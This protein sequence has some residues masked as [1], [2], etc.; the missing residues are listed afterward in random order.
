MNNPYA[1]INDIDLEYYGVTCHE[2]DIEYCKE[3]L[4]KL[5]EPQR[6]IVSNMY[7]LHF[8]KILSKGE[9][10]SEG[11]ARKHCN[12]LLMNFKDKYNE[13]TSGKMYMPPKM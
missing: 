3:Q 11:Q 10:K 5:T 4:Q 7:T 9:I 13:L 1:K 6:H 2:H 12:Q 8:N